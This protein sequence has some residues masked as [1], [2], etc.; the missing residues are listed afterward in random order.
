MTQINPFKPSAFL[1]DNIDSR[2]Y[3]LIMSSV[4]ID[5]ITLY[6]IETH[7]R[8]NALSGSTLFVFG[9]MI[10]HDSTLVDMTCIAF[11]FMYKR[12][13]LFIKLFIV[14]GA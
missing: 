12:E 14:D 11:V 13:S 9:N 6:P 10:R 5:H 4:A 8:Q 1:W 2:C 7:T 3:L